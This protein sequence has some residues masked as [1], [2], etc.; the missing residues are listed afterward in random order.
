MQKSR[1]GWA[2]AL[3]AIGLLGLL[4]ISYSKEPPIGAAAEAGLTEAAIAGYLAPQFTLK[5]TFGEEV[6]LADFRGRPVVL[7]FWA[8]WCPP[9]RA[10]IPHFQ[11]ASTK[12]NGQAVVL[13]VDQGEP[14]SVVGDFGAALGITYP[15]LL[16]SDNSVS[17]DYGVAAL[18]KT[19]FIDSDG[20]IRE[21]FTGIVNRAVLQD[22]IEK[23]LAES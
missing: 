20:V 19:V 3:V 1:L 9:C 17:R 6:S 22:R 5:N 2:I 13:G 10:E 7:N 12:Y 18:P 14:L 4:W 21:M 8:S 11:D 15:L 23:L 16:D